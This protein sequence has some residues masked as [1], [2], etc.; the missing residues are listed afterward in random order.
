MRTRTHYLP[1]AEVETGM[2]LAA[3]SSAASHGIR[4][5]S[6]AAGHQLTEDNLHQLRAHKVEYVFVLERDRRSD[7][8]VAI[9]AA[10]AA[11]RA[12]EIFADADLENPTT[13]ALFDQVLRFRSA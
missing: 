1:L 11:R 8:Q 4:R 13:A 12:L 7:E 6:L 3:A 5:F 10:M 2:V 9:D